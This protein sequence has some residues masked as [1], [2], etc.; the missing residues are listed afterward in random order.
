M[1]KKSLKNNIIEF[2]RSTLKTPIEVL[3]LER[4]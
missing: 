4:F 3:L 1:Q 2:E